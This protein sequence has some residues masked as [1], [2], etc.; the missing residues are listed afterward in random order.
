ME[1]AELK[2]K[3]ELDDLD[4][5]SLS[6]EILSPDENQLGKKDGKPLGDGREGGAGHQGTNLWL[7]QFYWAVCFFLS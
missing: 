3:I 4:S 7:T 2:I 1:P 5:S 6:S